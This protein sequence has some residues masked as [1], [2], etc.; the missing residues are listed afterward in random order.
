MSR[1]PRAVY[2]PRR[3]SHRDRPHHRHPANRKHG[4]AWWCGAGCRISLLFGCNVWAPQTVLYHNFSYSFPVW[5][6]LE[7]NQTGE[8]SLWESDW[9]YLEFTPTRTYTRRFGRSLRDCRDFVRVVVQNNGVERRFNGTA[10]RNP[11]G[12]WW[13]ES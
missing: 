7:Y 5:E 8:T 6:A 10:C 11:D 2:V 3:W 4:R 13:V 1:R 12:A 9:G